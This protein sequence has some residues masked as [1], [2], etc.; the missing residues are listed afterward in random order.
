MRTKISPEVVV[1][2]FFPN[3]DSGELIPFISNSKN[4]YN[5]VKDGFLSF[6]F[7]SCGSGD[8]YLE[9]NGKRLY[10]TTST[11]SSYVTNI[12]GFIPVKS[13]N[14]ITYKPGSSGGYYFY[15]FP[16]IQ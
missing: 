8:I 5:V 13:G 16:I 1:G 9:V 6:S 10:Y 14:V 3:F 11:G 15:F 4:T 2:S 7:Y 12:T